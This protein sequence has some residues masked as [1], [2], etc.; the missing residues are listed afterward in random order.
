MTRLLIRNA[1]HEVRTPLNSIINYLEFALEEALD[2]RARYHLQR[3]LQASKSLVFVVNDLLQL[4]EAENADFHIHEDNV[5]LRSILSEVVAAFRDEASRRNLDVRIEDDKAVPQLVRCDPAGLRQ[6][7]SNLLANGLQSSQDGYIDVGLQQIQT[8]HTNSVIKIF[9]KDEGTGLSEQQLDSIFQDFEQI[10]D[11]D[12]TPASAEQDTE[13]RQSRPLQIGLGLATAARFV[14]HHS[15]QISMSSEGQG[16]GTSVSITIPFRKGLSGKFSRRSLSSDIALQTPP[17]DIVSSKASSIP[18]NPSSSST[19]LPTDTTTTSPSSLASSIGRHAFPTSPVRDEGHKFKVLVAEDN[20]LNSRL[21]ETRL[22]RRGHTVQVVVDGKACVDAFKSCPEAF[23]VVL[24]DI[25]VRSL[26]SQ[27]PKFL[28]VQVE[29]LIVHSVDHLKMPLV[30]GLEA[31]CIIR[32]FEKESSSRIG[33]S[34]CV[35]SYGRIPII[36]VSASLSEQRVHEYE[37]IGFDGWILKPID[38]KRLEAILIAIK[39][40]QMREVLLYGAVGWDKGGW[41]KVKYDDSTNNKFE[42]H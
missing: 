9:F 35:A 23:D 42:E 37:E 33:F 11:D 39:H 1:G 20:P 26:C 28:A 31:T 3:S 13:E 17:L 32:N 29:N 10:L 5:D 18:N 34:T 8:T 24:M 30:D 7:I 21:L 12:E 22:K 15:G 27:V 6:V 40:V 41:F 2:E 25:Q 38:F 19:P 16:K 14:R 36:A 4:T